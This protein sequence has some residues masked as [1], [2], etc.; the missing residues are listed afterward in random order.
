M[1][2]TRTVPVTAWVTPEFSPEHEQRRQR[3]DEA[4]QLGRI[5]SHPVH[6]ADAS[7]EQQHHQDG[8]PEVHAPLRHEHAEQQPRGPVMTPADRSNSP[9]SSAAPPEPRRSRG[10]RRRP[11]SWATSKRRT[12]RAH[13]EQDEHRDDADQGA[14]LGPLQELRDEPDASRVARPGGCFACGS[15]TPPR[16]AL[17]GRAARARPAGR[18]CGQRVPASRASFW[19]CSA[20]S[21]TKPGPVSIGR[22]PPSRVR[23]ML[24][25]YSST[26]GR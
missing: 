11:T 5:T 23:L 22:P 15:T 19:T 9:R 1:P 18:E 12:R 16:M 13:R 6:Q 21:L 10:S 8:R 24:Y 20:L 25:R 3:D 2:P 14:D 26:T 17:P 7:G 4:G